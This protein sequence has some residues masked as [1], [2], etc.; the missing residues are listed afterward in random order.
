[1]PKI[2]NVGGRIRYS[3]ERFD[4][5]LNTNDNLSSIS[6]FESPDTLNTIFDED[7]A[8]A[9]RNGSEKWNTTL[10]GSFAVD[11]GISYNNTM[12]VWANGVMYR[13]SGPSGL[14]FEAITTSSGKF[15]TGVK[16]A[17]L[18]YQNILFTSDGTN[19]PWKYTGAENFYNMGI[20]TP[21]LPAGSGTSAGSI[22]TGTYY[23]AVSFVNSQAVEGSLGSVSA[24]ITIATSSA[25]GITDIPVGSGLAGVNQRFLYRA[26]AASGPF[27]KVQTIAD[28]T[29]TSV[30]DTVAN[31]A[32]GK[33]PIDDGTKPD[34]FRTIALHKE[35]LFFDSSTDRTF[36]RYTEIENPFIAP[37][38]NEEPINQGDGEDII[39]VASQ[40][41]FVTIFKKNKTFG[42]VTQDPADDL[43]WIKVEVPANIGIIGPKAF[44]KVQNGL[45]FVGRQNN[46][47]TGFHYL[48]GIEVRESSDGKLRSISIS[49]K[50]QPEILTRVSTSSWQH[51]VM[52]LYKN[53]LFMAFTPTSG[54]NNT[55]I[56]WLDLTRVGTGGQPG[57]WSE[58]T[59]INSNVFFGHAGHFFSGDSSATGF[60]RR[61]ETS[62]Y[63]DS[64]SAIESY[65][66]TKEIGGEKEGTL[67]SYVKDLRELYIWHSQLGNYFMNVRVR[68]DGDTSDGIA[69]PVNLS[70]GSEL[71]GSM[72]WGVDPWGGTRSDIESRL[73]MG[74][75][76]KRFQVGFTNQSTVTQGF[77]VHRVE[78]GFNIRR[79][80]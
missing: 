34:T 33:N 29:T 40:D 27:R 55:R 64:G 56:F 39:A 59:G 61:L 14:S 30:A 70:S 75:L 24:G 36:L 7:G 26:E 10:I 37:A 6:P 69:Y 17:A 74:Y 31:G 38:L 41:D 53:R 3:V 5:G 67:D 20:D 2:Q 76:G 73:V 71:W 42:V 80:R 18:V 25:I 68:A 46:F 57:S 47:I 66:W 28:N 45:I 51:I 4:G 77:K 19:G 58:W 1:M 62:S 78:L 32:E 21:S 22:S 54:S 48:N 35:R 9:T 65:F 49:E 13:N 8:V 11:W 12:I 63:N 60:V 79:R 50:I 23:Y 72:V 44:T 15:A 16:V 43:T 52:D